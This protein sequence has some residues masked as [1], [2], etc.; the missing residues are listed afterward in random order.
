MK[1][2][3]AARFH[4]FGVARQG[5]W[6]TSVN[7]GKKEGRGAAASALVL[8]WPYGL[9]LILS[10]AVAEMLPARSL[11]CTYTVLVP[12]PLLSSHDL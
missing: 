8:P 6:T 3:L 5:S 12:A 9:Y 2:A 7:K 1:I 4:D 10:Y 11:N